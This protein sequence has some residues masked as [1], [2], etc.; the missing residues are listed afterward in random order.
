MKTKNIKS[1]FKK[2]YPKLMELK[3]KIVVDETYETWS[4]EDDTII[5][6]D[7]PQINITVFRNFIFDVRLIPKDFKGITVKDVTINFEVFI[8]EDSTLHSE[9]IYLPE[10]YIKFVDTNLQLIRE[11]L[12]SP[13]MSR[14]EALDALT[15]NF[16]DH[17]KEMNTLRKNRLTEE[18]ENI[19]FFHELLHEIRAAYYLSDIYQKSKENKGY[20]ALAA[21]K[22]EVKRPLIVGF[23]FNLKDKINQYS[24]ELIPQIEYPFEKN[25]RLRTKKWVQ[26][27]ENFF[28]DYS[29]EGIFSTISNIC[30]FRAKEGKELTARDINLCKPIFKK[31]VDYL[32]PSYIISFREN[33]A[34]LDEHLLDIHSIKI[35]DQKSS[36]LVKKGKVIINSKEY[37]FYQLPHPEKRISIKNREKAWEFCFGKKI[38]EK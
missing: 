15:G 30:F 38:H 8:M 37:T 22:L 29:R 27:S 34:W 2:K 19:L 32:K 21:T 17:I 7:P 12:K 18:K 14:Y 23:N 26:K 13:N 24:E 25:K 1:S 36:I 16:E 20:Y 4:S 11:Q 3:P 28:I 6:Y 35:I 33:N 31:F 9:D 5:A 10:H